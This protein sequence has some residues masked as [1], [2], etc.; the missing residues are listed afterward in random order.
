MS[1]L[2]VFGKTVSGD[3]FTEREK[4]TAKLV[5]NFQYG[6][7][8]F[9]L[10]PRRWGKTS[11]VKKAKAIAENTKLKIVYVDVHL[12]RSREDFCERYASAILTQTSNKMEEWIDN[13]KTFLN[14]F[15]FGVNAS[16]DPSTEMT[17][18]MQLTPRE[19]SLEDLIQLPERIAKRKKTHVVVCID[20][21]QQIGLFPNSVQ[22][23]T[24][25]RSIW[26]HHEMTSYCLF[27]SKKHMMES[28]FDD[29][30]KP[31]YKFGDII[32]LQRIPVEYWVKYIT[33]KFRRE[34][35]NIS[36]KQARWIVDHVESNSSYV[37]QLSWYVFQRT[38]KKVDEN[39]LSDALTELVEQC[40]D[41]FEA[42]TE[43]L[44]ANQINFLRCIA[45]G[46][47]TGISS[48]KIIAAYN[49]GSSPIV[50]QLKKS[51]I[52]KDLI[53][54]ENKEV[55]LSDPVMGIWLK[56]QL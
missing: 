3:A 24:E 2:F 4:D 32:Y 34:G 43:N 17:F 12:C 51:L 16:A 5:S 23:Q 11:L 31:F 30:S 21:F 38:V 6:V 33:G 55:Y 26:Q 42:K 56:R 41:V 13:A 48:A 37:Q 10:S 18:K 27:G 40:A 52:E 50:A 53:S 35:K 45:D 47:H 15:S 28:F 29:S 36:E 46:I 7:N 9:L 54:I 49:L 44:T 39:I 20:E 22:F 8:T 14:R 19:Q 25:L 1:S